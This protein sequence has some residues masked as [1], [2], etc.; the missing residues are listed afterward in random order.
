MICPY[1][2]NEL[3]PTDVGT[4]DEQTQVIHECFTC[5]GHWLPRLVANEITLDT[6][7]SVDSIL[8]HKNN[9]PPVEPRCPQCNTRLSAVKTEAV[10][11]GV[12]VWACP[13][14]HGNFFPKGEL[15]KFKKAQDAK[16]S[17]HQ[18][19]GIPTK[20]VLAVLLPVLVVLSITAGL[21]LTIQQLQ[22]S[23]ESRTQASATHS[24]PIVNR[25][26]D[27]AVII[28]F[29]TSSAAK[30][31]LTLYQDGE[32]KSTLPISVAPTTSHTIKV[33]DL[34]PSHSY[35]YTITITYQDEN[36]ETTTQSQ[37]DLSTPVPTST[38][39]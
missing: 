11:Q 9:T 5:G 12:L 30:T 20:S 28:S 13:T 27:S 16:I 36:L 6:A 25:V 29:S 1:C 19:W 18:L 38:N 10:P 23:Q 3:Q 17:Y 35:S 8:I 7:E 37:I 14:G 34:D 32:L 2:N 22:H 33:R 31:V 24:T 39:N 26:S 4:K 15:Y 21:P